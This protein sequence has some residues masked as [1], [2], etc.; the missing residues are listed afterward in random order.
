VS[1]KARFNRRK[2]AYYLTGAGMSIGATGAVTVNAYEIVLGALLAGTGAKL[3]QASRKQLQETLNAIDARAS[4][5]DSLLA[6]T[7]RLLDQQGLPA[8]SEEGQKLLRALIQY[9]LEE[10]SGDAEEE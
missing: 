6:E 10:E 4:R 3:L 5:L 1:R 2:L 8:D 9:R 7:E